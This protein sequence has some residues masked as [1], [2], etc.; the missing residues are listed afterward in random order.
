MNA[1]LRQLFRAPV[2]LYRWNFGWMLGHRFLL[3]IHI[4]RRIGLRRHTVLEAWNTAKKV[5]RR[6]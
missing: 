6:S 1:A 4:G 5:L 2:Y 3:L